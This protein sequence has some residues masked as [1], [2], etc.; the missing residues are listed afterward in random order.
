MNKISLEKKGR[1]PLTSVLERNIQIELYR[2]LQNLVVKKFTFNDIEL[3]G[4]KFEPTIN[5]RPDLVVEAIDKG[6]KLSLLVI[7]TKKKVPFI[8]RKFDPYSKDVIRQASGYA[9]DLGAPYFATCN[10]EV[11]VLFDTFTAGVPLPQRRLKHYKVSLDEEFAKTILEEVCRFRVGLGKWLELDDVF[12]QRLRTFHTFITPFIL[13]ALNRQLN[14]D[15]KFKEEYVVWLK[16]QLFEYS[17]K[18]NETIAEQLA[19]MLMNRLTFYKTLETQISDLPKL[20]KVETEDPRVFAERLRGLFDKVCKDVDYEAIFEPHTILDQIILPKKLIY[21]LND[22]IEE[23]G[24]YDLS[25]I[26]SD[27][28]G[29]VYEE[30]IPDVERHRLGQ[31]YTPPPIVELITE[32][33]IKSANDK[34]LD[35]ACGSGGF[36][37][38]AY[39]KLK[40]LKKKENPFADDDK[41][42]EEIL[43]QLYGIDINA[44][45]AQ[46]SSIN[47][48]V[49]NLKVTSRNINLIVSDFFKV[50]PSIGIIPKDLDVVLTNPPYTRQEEMEYKDQIREEALTYSDGSKI[51]LDARA[52]IYAYFF[53]H[54]AKFMKN[55]G[56]MGQITSDTWLDVGFGVNLKRFFL[57]HFEIHA[58]IWYDIRAFEK[59]LV[60]TCIII[61]EKEEES[62]ENRDN[63]TVKFVRI[64]KTLPIEK[65]VTIIGT[66]KKDFEDEHIGITTQK[67]NK[68]EPQDKWGIFL[69]SPTI[70]LKILKNK[71]VTKL[72]KIASIKRGITSGANQFFYL[73]KGKIRLWSLEKEY[74]KPIVIS[75]KE[76]KIEVKPKDIDNWV[77]S[78]H[79]PKEELSESNVLRYIQWGEETETTIKGGKKGGSV[80]KGFHNLSTV[81]S[82]K[83]WYDIGKRE[84]A[85]I[86]RS[87]RIWEKCVYLLNKSDALANDSLYEIRPKNENDT[88]VL[89]GILNS[90]FAALVSELEGRFYGGGVLELEVYETKA[91]TVIDPNKIS[92]KE[93]QRIESAFSE[94]CEAQSKGDE[95]LEQEARIELDN[96][97]FDVLKLKES[98]RRQVYEGLESLRRMR[99]QRK[100]VDVLV[101]TAEKWKPLKKPKKEKKTKVEPSKR[102]DTWI[103]R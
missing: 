61:L 37:V 5:G 2:I 45:P 92:D 96:A 68:L 25:K 28:I 78:V 55:H 26:R 12:L 89:A 91:M 30:L 27:V 46:L 38:K 4:V 42:H 54:S 31:Y 101:E 100:E 88:L 94:V 79:K 20:R 72:G 15:L 35:P 62:K 53:T 97:V 43:N 70:Y 71:K 10:G 3:T 47:L 99:L 77:L 24:T 66:A 93:R 32:M 19:Y 95:K 13:E 48:A 1:L 90:S 80:V 83:L 22:F 85:P 7:E 98:E 8:D 58:I 6:K 81:T 56:M 75:P 29:R 52:G 57:E 49:R 87:R 74:L 84:P 39:H 40:D 9:V 63:N 102:L 73:D 69:R 64:K 60:G 82:R 44:F 34:V 16:S 50:K 18:M 36:L 51:P 14:E 21:T 65:I 103:K 67:Q 11:L 23:L 41:L 17:P 86:L 33:C 59:A 76:M